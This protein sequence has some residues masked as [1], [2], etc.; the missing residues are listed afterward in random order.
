MIYRFLSVLI[1]ISVIVTSYYFL[2]NYFDKKNIGDRGPKGEK[3][4][5]GNRGMNGVKGIRG[6]RGVVGLVGDTNIYGKVGNKGLKGFK[7]ERGEIGVR[8]LR[9]QDGERGVRGKQGDVGIKGKPGENGEEG[10]KGPPAKD[11][12]LRLSLFD[13]SGYEKKKTIN[14]LESNFLY[15]KMNPP[16]SVPKDKY[17]NI[18]L[19]IWRGLTVNDVNLNWYNFVNGFELKGE[20][21]AEDL[22]KIYYTNGQVIINP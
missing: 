7:G 18:L 16:V 9:G 22:S 17:L 14:T 5:K 15:N 10:I 1:F 3:G 21:N 19:G 8:G 13:N 2:L 4:D 12:F 6:K 20:N 11:N